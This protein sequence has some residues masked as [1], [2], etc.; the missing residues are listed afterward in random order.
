MPNLPTELRPLEE[1][2]ERHSSK[3]RRFNRDVLPMHV[4][5]MDYEIAPGIMRVARIVARLWRRA[6]RRSRTSAGR[7]SPDPRPALFEILSN[8][9]DELR[10]ASVEDFDGLPV[11]LVTESPGQGWNAVTKRL[12]D[13]VFAGLGLLIEVIA[14]HL[15]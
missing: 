7:W 5:E 10:N 13:I 2:R 4:A 11:V 6:R 14:R 12:F 9:L 15:P 8:K 3:W 1:L